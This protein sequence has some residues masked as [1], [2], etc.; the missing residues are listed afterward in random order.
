MSVK[1]LLPA[2]TIVG[3]TLTVI[4]SNALGHLN[5]VLDQILY[6]LERKRLACVKTKWAGE[7]HRYT[8]GSHAASI[9]WS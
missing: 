5:T 3:C 8:V 2:L 9:A 7:P 6:F 4:D 1:A